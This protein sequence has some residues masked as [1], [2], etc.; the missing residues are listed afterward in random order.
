VVERS[1]QDD[2]DGPVACLKGLVEVRGAGCGG[3]SGQGLG[4]PL[5]QGDEAWAEWHSLQDDL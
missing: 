5:I 4:N 2:C 1:L 3:R